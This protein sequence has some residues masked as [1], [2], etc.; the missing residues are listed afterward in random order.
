[1]RYQGP[2]RAPRVAVAVLAAAV[3]AAPATAAAQ[4]AACSHTTV[5]AAAATESTV[6]DAVRCLVNATRAQHGLP[7][8]QPSGRLTAAAERHSADM[9]RRRFFEHVSPEGHGVTDRIRQTGYLSGSGDW[10]LG[11]DIGWG[12]AELGTPAAIVQAWMNSPGHRAVI[13]SRRFDEAGVGV[14][15]G[16]PVNGVAGAENGL[17]YVLDVGATR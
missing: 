5:T 16:I 12:T 6:R 3:L 4:G 17:T 10:A 14:A 7:G 13:L 11:E 15:R 8:L 9:V 2:G 1:M